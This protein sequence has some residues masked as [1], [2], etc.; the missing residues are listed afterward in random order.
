MVKTND[1]Q[2]KRKE[3]N[4]IILNLVEF[5]FLGPKIEKKLVYFSENGVCFQM[6]CVAM[7][8]KKQRHNKLVVPGNT[9][10]RTDSEGGPSSATVVGSLSSA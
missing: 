9:C 6:D 4:S 5:I 8:A 1:R 3:H 7:C 10:F 2:S